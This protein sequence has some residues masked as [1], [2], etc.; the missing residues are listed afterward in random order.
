MFKINSFLWRDMITN[1]VINECSSL[2]LTI[3]SFNLQ[4]TT[5]D[6][7]WNVFKFCFFIFSQRGVETLILFSTNC[8]YIFFPISIWSNMSAEASRDKTA[9]HNILK[10]HSLDAKLT[11]KACAHYFL[12][13]FYSSPNDSPSKTMKNVFYF[14]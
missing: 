1:L 14:I 11:L 4:R 2:I 3:L 8:S 6:W 12:S 5:F 10:T 7:A 13:N 9:F